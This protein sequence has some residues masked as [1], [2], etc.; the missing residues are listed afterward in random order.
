MIASNG[1]EAIDQVNSQEYDVIFMDIQ[2]P[3]MGGVETTERIR[4]LLPQSQHPQIIAMTAHALSGDRERYL[5]QGL[6]GYLSKPVRLNDL[7]QILETIKPDS[8]DKKFAEPIGEAENMNGKESTSASTGYKVID[9]R[10]IQA[11]L[12][13]I[14]PDSPEIIIEIISLLEQDLP[15]HI[16]KMEEAIRDQEMDILKRTAHTVKGEVS[17]FGAETLVTLCNQIEHAA[18]NG[19]IELVPP[20]FETFKSTTQ[21]LLSDLEMYRAELT[22]QPKQ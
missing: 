5:S 10:L 21:I 14:D 16:E 7:L 12:E 13:A 22:G 17:H 9:K 3:E 18:A 11:Y 8:K 2:M 1:K 15:G 6:D 4:K 19:Q 20:L